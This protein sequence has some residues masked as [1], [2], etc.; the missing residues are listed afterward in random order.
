ME[1]LI[2]RAHAKRL[3]EMFESE[4]RVSLAAFQLPSNEWERE[5]RLALDGLYPLVDYI[6]RE[7]SD[8]LMFVSDMAWILE[9]AQE[10]TRDFK[11][12]NVEIILREEKPYVLQERLEIIQCLRAPLLEMANYF[13]HTPYKVS[14]HRSPHSLTEC[15]SQ[16]IPWR[17]DNIS[18]V[19]M[20][21]SWRMLCAI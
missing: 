12:G 18:Y 9:T 19:R 20:V 2:K 21:A 5:H 4:T 3:L 14:L 17:R 1:T 6:H 10:T 8:T 15:Q 13:H 7:G 11:Y 16:G